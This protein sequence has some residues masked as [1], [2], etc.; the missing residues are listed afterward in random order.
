M[1]SVRTTPRRLAERAKASR[2]RAADGM[3]PPAFG[4]SLKQLDAI[5]AKLEGGATPAPAAA[6]ASAPAP[7]AA[8]PAPEAKAKAKKKQ[9]APQPKKKKG[10][11]PA[12]PQPLFTK[13]DLRVGKIVDVW[14]HPDSEKL[15]CEKIDVGEPEPRQIVS[16]LRAW[17]T[18]EQMLGKRL[19]AVCNLKSAKLGGVAS[20]GMVM[21]AQSPK[22]RAGASA[23]VTH[24]PHATRSSPH[25][26]EFST[27][28]VRSC[29]RSV[30]VARCAEHWAER[31]ADCWARGDAG[32]G[33]QAV[34]GGVH[35]GARGR[36]GWGADRAGGLGDGRCDL[37]G[38]GQEAKG[39]GGDGDQGAP[40]P[41]RAGSTVETQSRQA[42]A[43]AC[44][45]WPFVSCCSDAPRSMLCV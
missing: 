35:R 28:Q 18:K 23:S 27:G 41:R 13:L 22:V 45:L 30:L 11:A 43:P 19:I 2:A 20:A 31:W 6:P 44:V 3:A 38:T 32:R 15:W 24:T 29:Q 5:I 40:L 37:A 36:A 16:G 4:E 1:R 39:V 33:R 9:P 17:Y 10:N 12:G 7:A 8:A 14:E 25:A 34:R 26:H 42:S 21:C